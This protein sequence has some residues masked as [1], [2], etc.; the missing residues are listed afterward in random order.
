MMSIGMK[1]NKFPERKRNPKLDLSGYMDGEAYL[2]TFDDA[3]AM[4]RKV[5]KLDGNFYWLNNKLAHEARSL[6]GN[7]SYRIRM[8]SGS[9]CLVD[10][11]QRE[12]VFQFLA[13]VCKVHYCKNKIGSGNEWCID[14]EDET[15]RVF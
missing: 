11:E 13:D 4:G 10:S 9:E 7:G 14:H 1:L 2:F 12:L 5:G 8:L 3:V 15:G 6:R